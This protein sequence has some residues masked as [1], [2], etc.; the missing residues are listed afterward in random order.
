MKKIFFICCFT[1]IIFPVSA[2]DIGEVSLCLKFDQAS[3]KTIGDGTEFNTGDI[4][5]YFMT[6]PSFNSNE[7]NFNFNSFRM[8]I[9]KDSHFYYQRIFTGSKGY[10][11]ISGGLTL[12][13]GQYQIIML[14]ETENKVLGKSDIFIINNY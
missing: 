10:P 13:A 8:I 5:W 11:C 1:L 4:V 7:Y 14:A 6:Y 9:N 2:Q 3:G 12:E